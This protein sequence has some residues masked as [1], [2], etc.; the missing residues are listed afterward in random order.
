MDSSHEDPIRAKE[1]MIE[2]KL[3][4]IE[5]EYG[6]LLLPKLY[7]ELQLFHELCTPWKDAL[8]VKLLGKNF[9]YNIMKD[10]LHRVWKLQRGFKI[11]DNDNG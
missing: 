6:N 2:K 8:V 7:L 10:R 3:V 5:L 1:D 11:M 9:G 4:C